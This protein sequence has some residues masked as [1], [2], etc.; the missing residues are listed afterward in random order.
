MGAFSAS[1][2]KWTFVADIMYFNLGF[3]DRRSS[4]LVNKVKADLKATLFSG[5]ALYRIYD[6]PTGHVN[7]GGG[8][9]YFDVDTKL[10]L[11]GGLLDGQS[12]SVDGSWTNP[13][14]AVQARF[15]LSDKWQT[16]FAADYGSFKNNRKTYQLTWTLDYSFADNWL[17]H[18]GYRYIRVENDRG[19]QDFR[20]EQ[21]GPV[22]GVTYQF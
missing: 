15:E 22:L 7:L 2:Q 21:S 13:V 4:L 12:S 10:S 11:N 17:A 9:R 5:Y 18:A 6:T 3:S 20:F 16:S 19:A 8:F 14:V 1:N